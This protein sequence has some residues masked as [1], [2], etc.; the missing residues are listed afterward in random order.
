[1]NNLSASAEFLAAVNTLLERTLAIGLAMIPVFLLIVMF[2]QVFAALVFSQRFRLDFQPMV[3]GFVLL[4]VL[5]FYTDF[6]D[7]ISATIQSISDDIGPDRTFM[8]SL[9]LI[10]L[11]YHFLLDTI[12]NL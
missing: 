9:F 8:P 2:N 10:Y 5:T 4:L 3:R 6:L 1:M 11:S 7:V 12:C